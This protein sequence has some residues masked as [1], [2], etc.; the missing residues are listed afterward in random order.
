MEKE[1]RLD[2]KIKRLFR[3]AGHPRWLH[4]RG[5]KKFESWVLCMGLIVRQLYKLSYRRAMKF[6]DEYYDIQ[7]HYTTLQKAAKRLPK[8][9]W[10]SL[11]G[12]T[13]DFPAVYLAGADG[14]CFSRSNPS[15][16]YLKRIGEK[17]PVSQPLQLIALADI[18]KRKFLSVKLHAKRYHEAKSIPH[19]HRKTPVTPEVLI[20]DKAFD[21][22]WLHK[23]L[24]EHNTF[25]IVPARKGCQRGQHRKIMRDCIDWQ[26]YWQRNIVESLFS[27]L[28]RL[29]G[30]SITSKTIRTQTADLFCRLI[31]YN[32]GYKPQRFSTKRIPGISLRKFGIAS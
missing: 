23:W 18:E 27:A 29:F 10:Q 7:M 30:T 11:L 12:A 31:A 6:L 9:L 26:L 20:M 24:K 21:A 28:K 13:I 19:L 17:I 3:R 4:S 32:T 15:F 1:K 25:S 2:R 16:H 22:E 8:S 14:T 5:P